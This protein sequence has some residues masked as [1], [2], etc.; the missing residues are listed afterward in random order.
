MAN[1]PSDYAQRGDASMGGGGEEFPPLGMQPISLAP[2]WG[3]QPRWKGTRRG[4]KTCAVNPT[5]EVSPLEMKKKSFFKKI[6]FSFLIFKIVFVLFYMCWKNRSKIIPHPTL[7]SG[8]VEVS[9][10]ELRAATTGLYS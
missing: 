1:G 9:K 4:K 8:R 3:T 6:W 7:L 2:S 5:E 10:E